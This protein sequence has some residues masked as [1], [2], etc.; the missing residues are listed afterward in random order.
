M[1]AMHLPLYMLFGADPATVSSLAAPLQDSSRYDR[2]PEAR[3]KALALDTL[4]G[5]ADLHARGVCCRDVRLENVMLR[6]KGGQ[7]V[8]VDLGIA[9]KAD[10]EGRLSS[11]CGMAGSL[12]YMAPELYE[13]AARPAAGSAKP[14]KGG[15]RQ[16]APRI[17]VKSDVYSL[18][19]TLLDCAV[20]GG[21]DVNRVASVPLR[22]FL[23]GL[24]A[25]NPEER[26]S[27]EEALHHPY[28]A[29]VP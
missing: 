22:E 26:L 13:G 20:R 1:C 4:R 19:Q 27:A 3:V 21:A 23:R 11:S 2:L 15:R 25:E 12:L 7:A 6:K 18:G 24:L 28:L 17:T 8:L 29:A 10:A 16:L 14:R 9:E 5:L